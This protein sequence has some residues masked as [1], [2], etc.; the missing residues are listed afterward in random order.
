MSHYRHFKHLHVPDQWE[1]YWSK[2]PNGFTVL[3][4]L[5]SWT[6]QVNDMIDSQ[7]HVSDQM[8]ALNIDFDALEKE[9]RMSWNGYKEHSVKTYDDF[10]AEIYTIVN[11]WIATIEPT[12]QD[13]TVKSLRGWLADGTLTDI[14]NKDVFDMKANQENL[15]ARGVNVLELS[16]KG[17]G[18]T[19]DTTIIQDILDNNRVVFFPSADYLID[20]ET[21]LSIPDD[22]IVYMTPTSRFVT[23]TTDLG[24]YKIIKIENKKNIDFYNLNI[25]GDMETHTGTTGEW[26]H[27]LVVN[28]SEN[29]N[30]YGTV[31]INDCWGD[32]LYMGSNELVNNSNVHFHGRLEFDNC[33]RQGASVISAIDSTINVL[34]AKNIRRTAPSAAL[35]IEPNKHGEHVNNL[36]VGTVIAENCAGGVQAHIMNDKTNVKI[37]RIIATKDVDIVF[38]ISR[39]D[40]G[41]WFNHGFITVDEIHILQTGVNTPLQFTNLSYDGSPSVDIGTVTIEKFATATIENAVVL[42]K[43]TSGINNQVIFGNVT[44]D[45]I[46]VKQNSS[47]ISLVPVYIQ[48]TMSKQIRIYN[49][50][51]NHFLV[52]KGDW[53]H[54]PTIDGLVGTAESVNLHIQPT[55]SLRT[56]TNAGAELE[57]MM[58]KTVEMFEYNGNRSQN[59]GLP[60]AGQGVVYLIRGVQGNGI[61]QSISNEGKIYI[62]TYNFSDKTYTVT[63]EI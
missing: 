9:L 25:I 6:S 14:I 34:S 46:V 1:Q 27:G 10:K 40:Q 11:N 56:I 4:A 53:S 24:S 59:V 30:F 37:G 44:I 41:Y 47:G 19:N 55:K 31:S 7:N 58:G 38:T 23:T 48:N 35:D 20:I 15:N 26:G 13:E 3:E 5:I 43:A 33:G 17:D 61:I 51:I 29:I 22:T 32:G 50:F 45:K 2:Y 60:T 12:I 42:I 16:A 39:A 57:K 36:T 8:T 28:S 49:V 62:S 18:V 54:Y 21:G 52:E 63:R